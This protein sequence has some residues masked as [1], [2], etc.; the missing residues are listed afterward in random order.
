M[1]L[2]YTTD[3]Y[4]DKKIYYPF[5]FRCHRTSTA[6]AY[7]VLGSGMHID[8]SSPIRSVHLYDLVLLFADL[9]DITHTRYVPLYRPDTN[10]VSL[11][12][13]TQGLLVIH[14]LRYN[15]ALRP[16]PATC[17]FASTRLAFVHLFL[18]S[19]AVLDHI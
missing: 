9:L 15:L 1:L 19:Q 7:S 14:I 5:S 6:T 3:K 8:A 17:K 10:A 4:L 18:P 2:L 13:L 12:Q 16:S 11:G